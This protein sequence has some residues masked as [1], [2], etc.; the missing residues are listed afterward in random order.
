[1]NFETVLFYKQQQQ[2]QQQHQTSEAGGTSNRAQADATP[3]SRAGLVSFFFFFNRSFISRH[4]P[5]HMQYYM[6]CFTFYS[7]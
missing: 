6:L 5:L 7:M 1:M 2:Q 4:V 3:A